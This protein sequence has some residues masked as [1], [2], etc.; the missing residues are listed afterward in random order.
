MTDGPTADPINAATLELLERRIGER[1]TEKARGQIF[2]YYAVVGTTVMGVLGLVGVNAV[3]WVKATANAKVDE[4]VRVLTRDVTAKSQELAKQQAEMERRVERLEALRETAGKSLDRV[5]QTLTSVAPQVRRLEKLIEQ[6]NDA[7]KD[8]EEIETRL[9]QARSTDQA[10]EQSRADIAKVSNELKALA[11]QVS[12]LSDAAQKSGGTPS[13]A[14]GQTFAA[15][16][17]AT[18]R[19]IA[20]S[21][22]I[23]RDVESAVRS[24]D[25]KVVYVQFAGSFTREKIDELRSAMAGSG[26]AVPPAERIGTAISRF[27]VRYFYDEDKAEAERLAKLAT[28]LARTRIPGETRAAAVVPLTNFKSLPKRGTLELWYGTRS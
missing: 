9:R 23:T 2:K 28:E 27:E 14:S 5:D 13:P 7:T 4:Q 20:S 21:E 8:I 1:V 6:I 24:E 15:I 16:T 18:K 17:E 11:A 26:F 3:E 19:V 10:V 25:R 12:S 22:A